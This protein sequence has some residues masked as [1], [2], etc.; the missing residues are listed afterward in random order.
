MRG[1]PLVR[2]KSYKKYRF[3]GYPVTRMATYY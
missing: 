2:A 3:F 1:R